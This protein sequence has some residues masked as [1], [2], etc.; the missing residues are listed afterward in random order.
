M[1]T[2]QFNLNC[3]DLFIVN[4]SVFCMNRNCSAYNIKIDINNYKNDRT[5]CKSF[6]K[7]NKKTNINNT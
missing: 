7:K 6:Y 1:L 3:S 4:C 2:V 5:V